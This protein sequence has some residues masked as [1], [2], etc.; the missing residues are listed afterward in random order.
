MSRKELLGILR[1]AFNES[2]LRDLC[3]QIEMD[4]EELAGQNKRDKARELLSYFE[5]RDRFDELMAV[6]R[7]LRPQLDWSSVQPTTPMLDNSSASEKGNLEQAIVAMERQRST[8][9]DAIVEAALVALQEKLAALQAIRLV[10]TRQRKYMTIL[11]ADISNFTAMSEMM[12]AEK[13][14]DLLNALWQRLDKVIVDQG[15][16]IDKHMGD[17][18]M[19]LFGTPIAREDDPE[20][21]IQTA[22]EMQAQLAHFRQEKQDNLAMRVG[23][24]TGYVLMDIVG[25]TEELT[26][27]GDTVNLA[28][29]LARAAPV[30]AILV[31]DY[32]Y[33]HVRGVFDVQVQDPIQVKGKQKLIQTYIVERIKPYIFRNL[34]RGIDGLDVPM[35]GRSSEM[36]RL[37]NCFYISVEDRETQ[38][39]T[40]SGEPGIGKSRLLYEFSRWLEREAPE[41]WLL[42]GRATAP[43]EKIPY[44]LLYQL[45]K[46]KFEIFDDDSTEIAQHKLVNGIASEFITKGVEKAHFIGRLL[47]FP[48]DDSPYLVGLADDVKQIRAR[49]YIYLNELLNTV[50]HTVPVV[51]FLEDAHWTDDATLDWLVH[52]V[53][54]AEHWPLFI[55]I[56]ARP[57]LFDRR[58]QWGEGLFFHQKI[59][60][61][62]LSRR[63]NRQLVDLLLDHVVNLPDTLRKLIVTH[64]EGNPFYAEELIKMLIEDGVI[65]ITNSEWQI[66]L[67]ELKKVYIPPTLMGI[68]QARLDRLSLEERETIHK[69]AVVGRIFWDETVRYLRGEPEEEAIQQSLKKLRQRDI[70]LKRVSSTFADTQEYAFKHIL[71]RDVA[72]E[73]VL[74]RLRR[75]YHTEIVEWILA[76]MGSRAREHAGIIAY[77]YEQAG[78]PAEAGHWYGLGGEQAQASYATEAAIELYKKALALLP[79][80]TDQRR[81][82]WLEGLGKALELQASF[83]ASIIVFEELLK[84]IALTQSPTD[85]AR[86]W[87]R[88]AL[89]QGRKGD[90]ISSMESAKRAQ[91]LALA[92]EPTPQEIL[93][94]ALIRQGWNAYRLGQPEIALSQADLGLSLS[95]QIGD[96]RQTAESYQLLGAV[97]QDLARYSE[98][99]KDEEQAIKLYNALDDLHHTAIML[100]NRAETAKSVGEFATAVANYEKALII[101]RDMGSRGS[102]MVVQLNLAETLVKLGQFEMAQTELNQLLALPNISQAPFYAIV[103]SHL[104]EAL[105]GQNQVKSALKMAQ[106][107]LGTA[108]ARQLPLLTGTTWRTLGLVLA[109][110]EE[111]IVDLPFDGIV[112][113][114]T[115][116]VARCFAQSLHIFASNRLIGEQAQTLRSWA[117][118]EKQQGNSTRAAGLEAQAQALQEGNR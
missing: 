42:I 1:T 7:Q 17:T 108:L 66:D 106:E 32:T 50:A 117:T 99:A 79:D 14:S 53:H 73:M 85:E 19:A 62:P 67:S 52:L 60:L 84:A 102:E 81:L 29:H 70:V 58:P 100:N 6:V 21:A 28:K 34:T 33:Q 74:L 68:L 61:R 76:K 16:W 82:V 40:L 11:F 97:K 27:L 86:I 87:N 118:I 111:D 113:E 103:Q 46:Q 64:S 12:D 83:D 96:L 109:Q 63:E 107:A 57:P 77:H 3:F 25:K 95:Q 101:F 23:I 41:A 65:I 22:I 105:L 49:A 5:R 26:A 115:T 78:L 44:A 93:A 72:Y 71:M 55:V 15:G 114:E 18:V 54:N 104:A 92:I 20:R 112:F 30:S 89:V 48:F 9:G 2:E 13:V 98:A 90:Y 43:M 36:A 75:F 110:A 91:T 4:Y 116:L 51:I 39:V 69:A 38:M 45:F 31:S 88:L 10:A 24:N 47:G 59:E 37:Q 8:L 80:K 94:Q 35:I 56:L